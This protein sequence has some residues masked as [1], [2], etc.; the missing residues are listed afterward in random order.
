VIEEADIRY[1]AEFY[2]RRYRDLSNAV[3]K[4]KYFNCA[5]P[6]EEMKAM[7]KALRWVLND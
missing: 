7:A 1:R 6:A 3:Q 5:L 4:K 2:E